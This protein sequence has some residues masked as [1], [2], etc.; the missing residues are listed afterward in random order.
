[1]GVVR[2]A[3]IVEAMLNYIIIHFKSKITPLAI[4]LELSQGIICRSFQVLEVGIISKN[5][6]DFQ[7]SGPSVLI[8]LV[9]GNDV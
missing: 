1:M 7:I 6:L 8:M 3:E 4:E 9:L 5:I 2:L